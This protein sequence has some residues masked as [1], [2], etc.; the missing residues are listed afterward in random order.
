MASSVRGEEC[1]STGSASHG[2]TVDMEG[3]LERALDEI[4]VRLRKNKQKI[5]PTLEV[6]RSDNS[7]LQAV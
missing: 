2:A 6:V 7:S 5:L 4:V 3:I 1:M